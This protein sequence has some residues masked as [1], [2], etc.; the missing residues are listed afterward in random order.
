[1]FLP[2]GSFNPQFLFL[3]VHSLNLG[4]LPFLDLDQELFVLFQAL[5]QALD[6]VDQALIGRVIIPFAALD[7]GRVRSGQASRFDELDFGRSGA[8]GRKAHEEYAEAQASED[9]QWTP[10]RS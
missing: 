6:L 3:F 1:M 5:L 7:F 2:A 4:L 9:S 10:T 8:T